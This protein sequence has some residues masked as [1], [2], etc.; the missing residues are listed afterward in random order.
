MCRWSID[1]SS[2]CA[3]GNLR[4]GRPHLMDKH[5]RHSITIINELWNCWN[6]IY[7]EL[8]SLNR[9]FVRP[10][11]PSERPQAPS[12]WARRWWP[13]L[14]PW[15]TCPAASAWAA[16]APSVRPVGCGG[17]GWRLRNQKSM[18]DIGDEKNDQKDDIEWLTCKPIWVDVLWLVLNCMLCQKIQ[19]DGP[20]LDR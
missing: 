14:G 16:P 5:P 17:S 18:G 7:N 10:V 8:A 2:S 15:A 19:L 13:R 20:T 12:P 1:S 4:L 3:L 9:H 6:T 11:A